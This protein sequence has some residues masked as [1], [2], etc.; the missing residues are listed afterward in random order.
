MRHRGILWSAIATAP[1]PSF[2]KGGCHTGRPTFNVFIYGTDPTPSQF[3]EAL[4][5]IRL[6]CGR[7][8]QGGKFDSRIAT[9][10]KAPRNRSAYTVIIRAIQ[11]ILISPQ[12]H[13][14]RASSFKRFRVHTTGNRYLGGYTGEKDSLVRVPG[15]VAYWTEAV[16][17][18]SVAGPSHSLLIP[19]LQKSPRRNGSAAS[20]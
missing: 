4:N 3:Q 13:L 20:R 11:S 9:F 2:S 15:K 6:V 1:A 7:C 12:K 16:M 17:S 8:V 19:G 10:Q 14:S 18:T 5:W